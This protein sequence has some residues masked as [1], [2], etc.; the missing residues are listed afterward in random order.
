ML[1]VGTVGTVVPPVEGLIRTAQS[2]ERRYDSMWWPDHLMGWLPQS[3]WTTDI[4]PLAHVMDNPHVFLDA[5]AAMAAVAVHTQTLTLG[6]SVTEPIRRHPAMLAQEFLTLD[7]LS[8][9]RVILGLGAGEL[10]NVEPYGLDYRRPVG[11]FEE[12]L[13]IIRLLWSTNEPVDFDG[14]FW[15]LRDAVCGI[16]PFVREDGTATP[17][18]IWSGAHGPR[19]LDIVGRLCD[20]WLPTYDGSADRWSQRL[21]AIHASAT[22]ASRDPAT[23]TPGMFAMVIPAEDDAELERL[24]EDRIVKAWMLLV[25]SE[26][27][28]AAGH[29]HPLGSPW[30]GLTDYVPSRLGRDEALK[31]IDAVPTDICRT[32][33][34]CGTPSTIAAELRDFEVRGLQHVVFQNVGFMADPMKTREQF[35]LQAEIVEELRRLA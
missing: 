30:Y 10:E 15:T 26:V 28:E 8:H 33:I 17:P 31:A 24:L 21:D 2:A 32:Y 16:G 35:Q 13:R 5:I 34:L 27:Y 7:H 29:E 9:G 3:I 4:T 23:I 14:E 19:M 18:P 11:R 1:K 20:G 25:P 12:A 6:T 22:K